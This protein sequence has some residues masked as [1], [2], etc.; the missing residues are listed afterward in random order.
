M[1]NDWICRQTKHNVAQWDKV[2]GSIYPDAKEWNLDAEKYFKRVCEECN[3]LNSIELIEWDQY[4]QKNSKI[5]DLGC[6]GGWLS[7]Y[8][9]KFANVTS[10]FA[11]DTSKNY[12]FNIMPKVIKKVNGVSSKVIPIEG[13]FTPIILENTSLDI[14]VASASLHHA[15]NLELILME[16]HSKLKQGGSLIIL[17]ETPQ[18]YL[19]YVLRTI[20]VFIEIFINTITK[21]YKPISQKI[22]SS[23]FE[24]DP[25][26]GDRFYPLWYWEVILLKSGF[27]IIK[28]IDS[29]LPTVKNTK[30]ETLKHF[31]CKK[32]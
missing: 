26:L 11:I 32:I 22:S 19:K 6:G 27:K 10:I 17:N 29:E 12:L 13:M 4:I 7:A 3:F 24:Y 31:I 18:S 15:D 8:L 30:G 21:Q 23:G 20:K 1:N 16:I 25:Y 14:V 28:F 2:M 9:S 5:L